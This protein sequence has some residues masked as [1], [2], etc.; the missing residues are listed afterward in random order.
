KP[1]LSVGFFALYGIVEIDKSHLIVREKIVV[2]LALSF[3]NAFSSAEAFEVS[4]TEIG[5]ITIIGLCD[6]AEKLDF[7]LMIG[8]HF[9]DSDFRLRIERQK[10]QR[11]TDMVVQIPHGSTCS[12]ILRKHRMNEFLRSSFAVASSEC[13]NWDS[14]ILAVKCS[15]LLKRGKT[16][17]DQN[18]AVIDLIFRVIDYRV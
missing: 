1:L 18:R 16:V 11:D 5:D 4:F 12:E 7:L 8:A 6:A 9:D 3:D 10:R 2:H 15:E 17:V 14:Q 13:Y